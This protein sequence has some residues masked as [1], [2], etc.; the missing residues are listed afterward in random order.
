M[1]VLPAFSRALTEVSNNSL[2][3]APLNSNSAL[4]GCMPVLLLRPI[5]REC[6]FMTLRNISGGQEV[7]ATK[8]SCEMI[9][10]MCREAS[11][12]AKADE[13]GGY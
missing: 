7:A 1:G 12:E 5:H 10:V 4:A 2:L 13:Q 9:V 11:A 8:V 6:I 3:P